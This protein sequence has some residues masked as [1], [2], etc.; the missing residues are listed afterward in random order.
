MEMSGIGMHAN[1]IIKSSEFLQL[2]LNAMVIFLQSGALHVKE[3][4]LWEA[5]QKWA[6]YQSSHKTM[7]DSEE[8]KEEPEIDLIASDVKLALLKSVAPFIRFGLMDGEY[9]AK[10]VKPSNIL[11][12][13]QV[14]VVACYIL[15]NDSDAKCGEFSTKS[16][17]LLCTIS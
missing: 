13:Q 1:D 5:V 3:E 6:C 2:T 4:I 17:H 12:L 11:S 7:E 15:S 10:Q 8:I 9:F 14:A 16:R